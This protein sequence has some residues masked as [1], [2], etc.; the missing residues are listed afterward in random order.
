V[1]AGAPPDGRRDRSRRRA[2]RAAVARVPVPAR[3]VRRPV[4]GG[5][6]AT[7]RRPRTR[8]GRSPADRQPDGAEAD[9]RGGLRP[10]H[11]AREQPGGGIPHRNPVRD[12]RARPDRHDPRG[13]DPPPQRLPD[14]GGAG[15]RGRP[16]RVESGYR[17]TFRWLTGAC[18]RR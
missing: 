11:P 3:R 18:K 14:R 17:G 1:P 7:T 16:D 5:P 4:R 9:G 15:A 2:S 8:G 10:G 12:R 6:A 13:T